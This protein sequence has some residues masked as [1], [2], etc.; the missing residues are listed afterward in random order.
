MRKIG[1]LYGLIRGFLLMLAASSMSGL[2]DYNLPSSTGTESAAKIIENYIQACGG[3]SLADIKTEIRKG[4]LLRGVS[5]KVPLEITAKK[6]GKWRYHQAFAWGDRVCYG[7]DGSAAWVQDTQSIR[8]MSSQQLREMQ[9]LMDVQFPLKIQ[10]FYPGM[11]VTGSETVGKN[12]AYTVLA[13]SPEGSTTEFS[14]DKKN[15]LLLRAGRMVFE[16]YRDVGHV[17]RP[18]RIILGENEGEKHLQ[19][20][21]EFTETQHNLEVGD[22][23]F[24]QPGCI[25]TSIEPPLY[26]RRNPVEV[27]SKDLEACVGEYQHPEFPNVT[28]T[29]TR[30]QNHLMLERTGW[31]QRMEIKPESEKDYYMQFLNLDFH[32]IKDTSGQVTHLV[33]KGE[34]LLKAEKIK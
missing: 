31:G 30:Q 10:E 4:T 34:Q 33:I 29:V 9:I 7:C 19:M 5:G 32:F 16:D 14:F 17:K 8:P 3:S 12:E 22:S 23:Q 1:L 25:L 2:P 11:M 27:S 21:M 18:F 15:G 20:R 24:Q 26:K 13:T 28:Y 6:P